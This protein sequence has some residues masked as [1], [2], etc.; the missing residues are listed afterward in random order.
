MFALALRA[1]IVAAFEIAAK[2][3]TLY[4]YASWVELWVAKIRLID[5]EG[6][7]WLGFTIRKRLSPPHFC[8]S[9]RP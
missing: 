7:Q 9:Y 5:P 3:P 1:A 2:V 8:S 4:A 6:D